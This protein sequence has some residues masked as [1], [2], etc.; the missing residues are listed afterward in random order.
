ML[1]R[2]F[3]FLLL[4]VET[5]WKPFAGKT[6]SLLGTFSGFVRGFERHVAFSEAFFSIACP[7]I[8]VMP[9]VRVSIVTRW[10]GS[11][12]LVF[13]VGRRRKDAEE[14]TAIMESQLSELQVELRTVR[15]VRT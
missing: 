3:S 15:E 11:Y 12:D 6:I 7:Y 4:L 10:M 14:H 2:S 13:L 9:C 1:I 5:L 8:C